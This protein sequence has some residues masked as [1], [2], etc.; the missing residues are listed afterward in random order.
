MTC[1]V[2]GPLLYTNRTPYY[3]RWPTQKAPKSSP[4]RGWTGIAFSLSAAT[5][6]AC[7]LQRSCENDAIGTCERCSISRPV[8]RLALS[9]RGPSGAPHPAARPIAPGTDSAGAE[10][11]AVLKAKL[12]P[13]LVGLTNACA[14]PGLVT[15]PT[16]YG[17]LLLSLAFE[18]RPIPS[19]T[20]NSHFDPLIHA[21]F[22]LP[23]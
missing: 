4:P 1:H 15:Q 9:T 12:L 10:S 13:V 6:V 14:I 8:W 11:E 5:V 21:R 22:E 19:H 23:P 16:T 20:W 3:R 17:T 18:F 2:D 7:E